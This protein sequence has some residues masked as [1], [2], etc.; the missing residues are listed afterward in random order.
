[1]AQLNDFY[2]ECF[3]ELIHNEG[4]YVNHKHD[5]GGET[6]MG[7]ARNFHPNWGGWVM[8]DSTQDKSKLHENE[9]LTDLVRLFY[10]I[11]YWDKLKL[12]NFPEG[13]D[14]LKFEMFDTGVN[15]GWRRASKLLQRSLNILNRNEKIVNDIKVDG[16]IGS[17]TL[18]VLDKY[19]RESY[20]LFKL[21]VLMKAKIYI[22]ILENNHTQEAFARGWINRIQLN[23]Q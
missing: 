3:N 19:K 23:K 1:M 7:I 12:D 22:D 17:G 2:I 8:I 4:G 18:G 21:F 20:Y 15:M 6:Y 16:I 9:E 5:R 10:K 14:D 13:F 11:S